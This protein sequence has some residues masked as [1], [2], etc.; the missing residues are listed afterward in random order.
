M[1]QFLGL[2]DVLGLLLKAIVKITFD[3]IFT[4]FRYTVR[5]AGHWIMDTFRYLNDFVEW[6]TRLAKR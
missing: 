6:V 1:T 3:L 2:S 4:L 5:G